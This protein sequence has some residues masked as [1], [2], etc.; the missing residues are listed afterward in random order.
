MSARALPLADAEF[1]MITD[2]K[3]KAGPAEWADYVVRAAAGIASAGSIF[4]YEKIVAAR[5]WLAE[6]HGRSLAKATDNELHGQPWWSR[7]RR[8]ELAT[9]L[10]EWENEGG[11]ISR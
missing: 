11:G 4:G 8:D 9:A 6:R 10:D 1:I 3:N 5:L 2:T 7:R